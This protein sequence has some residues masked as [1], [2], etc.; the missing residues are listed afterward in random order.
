MCQPF[1][2]TDASAML[3]LTVDT[4]ERTQ[5]VSPVNSQARNPCSGENGASVTGISPR[6]AIQPAVQET[7][8]HDSGA[9]SMES[10]EGDSESPELTSLTWLPGF[11]CKLIDPEET[12]ENAK[13]LGTL[14]QAS[15]AK[16]PPSN[17]PALTLSVQPAQA[18]G[19]LAKTQTRP[20]GKRRAS[21]AAR[22][23]PDKPPFKLASLIFMAIESSPSKCLPVHLIYNWIMQH[24]PYYQA[25]DKQGPS[26]WRNSVRHNLSLDKAFVKVVQYKPGGK[27]GD[28]SKVSVYLSLSNV[29]F[30]LSLCSRC[31]CLLG[32]MCLRGTR[33]AAL[34]L[35]NS[36]V[37][38][39]LQVGSRVPVR[40]TS[41]FA[42]SIFMLSHVEGVESDD[43]IRGGLRCGWGRGTEWKKDQAD[44]AIK[45]RQ[46]R[47][48]CAVQTLGGRDHSECGCQGFSSAPAFRFEDAFR[49][50]S[51]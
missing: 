47:G 23:S 32:D 48:A 37:R 22:S 8:E 39:F 11:D 16:Q 49:S 46:R 26:N 35:L 31:I 13:P 4:T 50:R 12:G 38:V 1:S 9:S 27:K 10:S 40:R 51:Q 24:Y 5:S 14:T 2:L 34:G 6:A 36:T 3:P 44:Y 45:R 41:S 7:K 28:P 15:E 29:W 19:C 18:S 21:R 33:F 42:H 43:A 30:C 25:L 17:L 20:A